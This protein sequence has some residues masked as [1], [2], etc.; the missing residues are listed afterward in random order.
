MFIYHPPSRHFSVMV[1]PQWTVVSLN[2]SKT[3]CKHKVQS[4]TGR[5]KASLYQINT[6]KGSVVRSVLHYVKQ[7]RCDWLS[8]NKRRRRHNASSQVKFRITI[9]REQKLI[10]ACHSRKAQ[11]Q[12]M[13]LVMAASHLGVPVIVH[14]CF[15]FGLRF[16]LQRQ[17]QM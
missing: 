5:P 6:I 10:S 15:Q 2:L 17:I 7:T 4:R 13:M 12:L 14:A 16:F 9:K 1:S 8:A 3:A 11:V